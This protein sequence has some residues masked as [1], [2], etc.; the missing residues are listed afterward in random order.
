MCDDCRFDA[1]VF[2]LNQSY[3]VLTAS[4]K[5]GNNYF[6]SMQSIDG[7]KNTACRRTPLYDV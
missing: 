5:D 2:H 1:Y 3:S 4:L 7:L 6:Y